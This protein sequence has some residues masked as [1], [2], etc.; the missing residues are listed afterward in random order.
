[1]HEYF[2]CQ[3]HESLGYAWAQGHCKN[4]R[5]GHKHSPHIDGTRACPGYPKQV[6]F[7]LDRSSLPVEPEEDLDDIIRSMI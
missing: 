3:S 6:L 4:G 5:N 2:I 1:M 7:S